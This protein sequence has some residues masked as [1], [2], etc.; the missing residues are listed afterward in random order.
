M[1]HQKSIV[2][3]LV[4]IGVTG[5]VVPGVDIHGVVGFGGVSGD[6]VVVVHGVSGGV[7]VWVTTGHV[8]F[9]VTGGHVG[10]GF[11]C[12]LHSHP[13]LHLQQLLTTILITVCPSLQHIS[14]VTS[15]IF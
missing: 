8:G 12:S 7:H 14:F 3:S 10:S 1:L 15:V 9:G 13:H 2:T 4:N 6:G 5:G 11:S